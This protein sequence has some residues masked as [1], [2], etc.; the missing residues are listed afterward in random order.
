MYFIAFLL[1][2][3][4][5]RPDLSECI[6]YCHL[7]RVKLEYCKRKLL[8]VLPDVPKWQ[9]MTKE[10][11]LTRVFKYSK[12]ITGKNR[13]WHERFVKMTDVEIVCLFTPYIKLSLRHWTCMILPPQW[14][15]CTLTYGCL[16]YCWKTRRKWERIRCVCGVHA[17]KPDDIYI[18]SFTR[19]FIQSD[20]QTV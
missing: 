5:K 6:I 10:I 1:K 19:G 16:E 4:V 17:W 14:K 15:H 2:F 8:D 13:L 12:T 9:K 7:N 18:K 11:W 3:S 20:L